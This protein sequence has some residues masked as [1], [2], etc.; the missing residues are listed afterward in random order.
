MIPHGKTLKTIKKTV[1]LKSKKIDKLFLASILR[2][3]QDVIVPEARLFQRYKEGIKEGEKKS[4]INFKWE[5][6]Q[7]EKLQKKVIDFEKSSGVKIDSWYGD[8]IGE[9]VKQVL[10]GEHTRIKQRLKI[11]LK[12]AKKIVEDIEENLGKE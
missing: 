1:K 4:Q 5:K 7:Y 6:E 9:A 12:E 11:L 2:K 3:A 10:D 8:N